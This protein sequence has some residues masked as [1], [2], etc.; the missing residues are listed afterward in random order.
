MQA[1]I[2]SRPSEK[3]FQTACLHRFY[4]TP[5]KRQA[6]S[7]PKNQTDAKVLFAFFM[8]QLRQH[9]TFAQLQQA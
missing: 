4:Q 5:S 9:R 1:F 7:C 3:G 6:L 8:T 2:K